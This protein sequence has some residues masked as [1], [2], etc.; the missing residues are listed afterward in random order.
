MRVQG[1][2]PAR[3]PSFAEVRAWAEA[4]GASVRA[5]PEATI[6]VVLVLEELFTNTVAHGYPAGSEGPV[7][8]SLGL[9]GDAIE[10][11]YEDACP[12]F[13]P[14][15]GAPAVPRPDE[16]QT[17]GGV[18]LALVRGLSASA[19]YARVGDRNR[20]ILTVATGS[21]ESPPATES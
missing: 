13:D 11:T 6:R 15:G 1:S 19:R 2:Y 21:P 10:I 7:W 9:T 5:D 12:P 20:V 17:L 18:G 4:F 16:D 8:I 14:I 3:L